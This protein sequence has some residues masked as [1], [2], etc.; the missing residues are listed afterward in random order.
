M[1]QLP[2]PHEGEEEEEEEGAG[3]RA[4]C[5]PFKEEERMTA[6]SPPSG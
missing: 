4:G 1:K 6:G 3:T 2:F 5:K